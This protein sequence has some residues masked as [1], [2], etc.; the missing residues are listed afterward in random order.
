MLW[1]HGDEQ[2]IKGKEV[3]K[4]KPEST[5]IQVGGNINTH[6]YMII[7][8]SDLMKLRILKCQLPIDTQFILIVGMNISIM[9]TSSVD[10]S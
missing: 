1:Y 6:P 10:L 9:K 5:I 4:R 7:T 3:R 2:T 8:Q